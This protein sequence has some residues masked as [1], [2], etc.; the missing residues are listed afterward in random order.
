MGAAGQNEK[1]ILDA[2]DS[3]E[4]PSSALDSPA[5]STDVVIVCLSADCG[6]GDEQTLEGA[7]ASDFVADRALFACIDPLPCARSHFNHTCPTL[8]LVLHYIT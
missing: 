3:P 8:A 1:V 2:T 4:K 6:H 5:F 7:R